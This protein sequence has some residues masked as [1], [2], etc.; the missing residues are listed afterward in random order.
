MRLEEI[1]PETRPEFYFLED[2]LNP[3]VYDQD[4][5]EEIY[6]NGKGLRKRAK[7][8][9][10]LPTDTT[11]N[12]RIQTITGKDHFFVDLY[13]D[14]ELAA[15][16][17]LQPQYY[18][19][20]WQNQ[21][22]TGAINID[23]EIGVI[24]CSGIQ[25]GFDWDVE[26]NFTRLNS[27]WKWSVTAPG[28]TVRAVWIINF[29]A[30]GQQLLADGDLI[31]D[32]SDYTG[33]ISDD[34]GTITRTIIFEPDGI[35]GTSGWVVDPYLRVVDSGTYIYIY[36]DGFIYRIITSGSTLITS[37][38]RYPTDSDSLVENRHLI[39]VS[40]T[41]YALSAYDSNLK[42]I[43]MEP[44]PNRVVAKITGN[45]ASTAR[46]YASD[47]DKVEFYITLYKDKIFYDFIW[48]ATS[49]LVIQ[50][51]GYGL[52]E[53][54]YGGTNKSTGYSASG[55]EYTD[56]TN[57]ILPAGYDYCF[58]S[59]DEQQIIGIK[60]D[61]ST[62]LTTDTAIA[63]AGEIRFCRV[64]GTQNIQLHKFRSVLIEDTIYR[65]GS[66]KL[67]NSAASR[68]LLS[69]Q[70]KD[71]VLDQSPSKGSDVTDMVL[72]EALSSG[73]LHADGAHHYD[74]DSNDE[75]TITGDRDRI[76]PNFVMHNHPFYSGS[77][78]TDHLI[79]KFLFNDNAAS[80]TVV[81][82]VGN[83]AVWEESDGTDRNTSNDTVT[84]N[85]VRDRGLDTADTYHVTCNTTVYDNDFFK[86]GAVLLTF[87]P[88]WGYDDA[89]DQTL[90]HLYIDANNQLQLYYSATNDRY[91]FKVTWGGTATT[92]NGPAHTSNYTLQTITRLLAS[93][94]S[95]KDSLILVRY[96]INLAS[97]F[98]TGTPSSSGA[99]YVII[100]ANSD[101]D[102]T[103]S[104]NADVFLDNFMAF[105]G[106]IRPYGAYF[107]G[108]GSVDTD[109]AH[110]GIK[111][112]WGCESTS[113]EIG[114]KTITLGSTSLASGNVI[115]G[116]Y[117]LDTDGGNSA[118]TAITSE[119]MIDFNKG[120]ISLWVNVQTWTNDK[121]IFTASEG[122]N[123]Y[124][125]LTITSDDD[126][127]FN[128]RH[129]GTN[130]LV[131]SSALGAVVNRWYYIRVTWDDTGKAYLYVNGISRGT[132]NAVSA[133][134]WAGDGT[135]TFYF[136][137]DYEGSNGADVLIDQVYITSDPDTPEVWTAFGK[138][139]HMP[140]FK[141]DT[142]LQKMG[143][144]YEAAWLPDGAILITDIGNITGA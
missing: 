5:L 112:Y 83:N 102:G 57:T 78:P 97:G 33:N 40:S 19:N 114:S 7:S 121:Y 106:G 8:K 53:P 93:W 123:N 37:Q 18:Q 122:E 45:F 86:K 91:E 104:L 119:D 132:P 20:G 50:S 34:L 11:T 92:I 124:I 14:N 29:T 24:T 82:T 133:A 41:Y 1:N 16:W 117:V 60:L 54:T 2:P 36:C 89:A 94:D 125:G 75:L 101:G 28:I 87:T 95:D 107:T 27:K 74:F 88:Q 61:Y 71:F 12:A 98:N 144:G 35:L 135:G 46:V 51:E 73:T 3:G 116:T 6:P 129:N 105:D 25:G 56:V 126:F 137:G 30:L 64:Y 4:H 26:I 103:T 77:G 110:S 49:E 140:L 109:V 96:G 115:D 48:N 81:A 139:L 138:P 85:I 59:A 143:T 47:N 39:R 31:L 66:A 55:S 118:S 63:G 13:Y 130:E 9:S 67:Y 32:H 17:E 136:G 42:V 99:A 10:N 120:S 80:S 62:N 79:E 70:L 142:V 134:D 43:I 113:S 141:K 52:F 127:R 72:P 38:I 22:I 15:T 100:G 84:T 90:F 21:E 111:F 68:L 108:N 44:G 58:G 69:S 131:T 76:E 128:Y 65:A 23:N